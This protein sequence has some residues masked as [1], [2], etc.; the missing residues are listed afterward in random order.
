[1][2]LERAAKSTGL[3]A[4][5]PDSSLSSVASSFSITGTLLGHFVPLFKIIIPT[6]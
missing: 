3:E 6:L 5:C 2:C 4:R 1:M